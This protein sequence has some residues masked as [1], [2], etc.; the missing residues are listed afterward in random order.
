M[1][2]RSVSTVLILASSMLPAL[3]SS[4]ALLP[5]DAIPFKELG[6]AF[7]KA[8]CPGG[9]D[10]GICSPEE[11]MAL[12]YATARVG[13][14]EMSF[15]LDFFGDSKRSGEIAVV[16]QA[17]IDLQEEWFLR[18]AKEPAT[19]EAAKADLA[20][21]EGWIGGW[22]KAKLKKLA[23][24]AEGGSLFELLEA[25]D[26]VREASARLAPM[27][28]DAEIMAVV[29]QFIEDIP[30]LFSAT[31]LNFMQLVGYAGIV[32]PAVQESTWFPSTADWTQF[33]MDKTMVVALQYSPWSDDPKFKGGLSMNK[34]DKGGQ[35]QH[36]VQQLADALTNK[37]LNRNDVPLIDKGLAVH[38][39]VAVC[40][41]A[42]T[43]D[44]EGAITTSG[45]QTRPYSRFVPG[46]KSEGGVLP[47]ASAQPF[48]VTRESAWRKA[49]VGELYFTALQDGQ[50]LGG[51]RVKKD[52]KRPLAKRPEAHFGLEAPSGKKIAV[53]APFLGEFSS[54]RP[55]PD[56]EYLNDFREFFRAYQA[57]FLDWL[58]KTGSE[59]DTPEVA[60]E[61]FRQLISRLSL[62]KTVTIDEAVQG[63]YD[64]P[65]STLDGSAGLE[66]RFLQWLKDN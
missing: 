66:W 10:S 54:Q 52:K 22:S 26:A 65:L 31:R 39:T 9:A 42:N 45:A 12:R 57:C 36:V 60:Q 14:F 28:Y 4:S 5:Q 40:G 38:M 41:S 56:G 37:T 11:V 16:I 34:F 62:E 51:K 32:F 50:A 13:A 61:K 49:K 23:K 35:R 48:N 29:P 19:L 46:G 43:V 30:V 53:T 6:E 15:H 8:N 24:D 33:W 25:E 1:F 59:G 27:I 3:A 7:A 18:F 58:S 20:I 55:Y 64:E 21:L 47:K 44:G 17:A 63:V 2:V